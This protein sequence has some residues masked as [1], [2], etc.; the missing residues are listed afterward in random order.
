V[1]GRGTGAA[2]SWD[3]KLEIVAGIQEVH[4]VAPPAT[5]AR[6]AVSGFSGSGEWSQDERRA[7]PAALQPVAFG[8]EFVFDGRIGPVKLAVHQRDSDRIALSEV[9]GGILGRQDERQVRFDEVGF[10]RYALDTE[11]QRLVCSGRHGIHWAL[12]ARKPLGT[13]SPS[14]A[15][16]NTVDDVTIKP[17][18]AEK[19]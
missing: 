9:Q 5:D 7:G 6:G 17:F 19:F 15:F 11:F 18:D 2:R 16:R 14:N 10:D 4:S 3:P 12:R 13:V 8:T 1:Q